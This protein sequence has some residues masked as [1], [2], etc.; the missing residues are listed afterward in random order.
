MLLQLNFKF[1]NN[2][3]NNNKMAAGGIA[4]RYIFYEEMRREKIGWK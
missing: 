3:N 1:N 2:N 4:C